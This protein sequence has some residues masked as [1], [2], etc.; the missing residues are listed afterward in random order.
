MPFFFQY[1]IKLLIKKKEREKKKSFF[2]FT[3]SLCNVDDAMHTVESQYKSLQGFFNQG[4]V[5][6]H[7]NLKLSLGFLI[8]F[9]VV[10]VFSSCF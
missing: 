6:L 7:P 4:V 2:H 5:V 9:V 10:V 8:C 1:I 3:R